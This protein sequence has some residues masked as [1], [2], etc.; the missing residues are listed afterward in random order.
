MN[1]AQPIRREKESAE[2]KVL[3]NYANLK[4]QCWFTLANYVNAGKIGIYRNVP[5]ETKKLIIEDLEQIK[6]KDPG[7]DRPLRVLTKEEIKGFISRST[8]CGD[9]MMMRMYFEINPN[10]LVFGFISTG[11]EIPEEADKERRKLIYGTQE[12]EEERQRQLKKVSFG[13]KVN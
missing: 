12:Y 3:H 10:E 5:V 2:E 9:T 8:D 7:K 13:P 6:Q 4:S 1:N 11:K